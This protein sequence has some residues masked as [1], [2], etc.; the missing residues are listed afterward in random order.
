MVTMTHRLI[1]LSRSPTLRVMLLTFIGMLLGL[2]SDILL[3]AK[4]GTSQTTDALIVALS[5][6]RLVDLVCREGTR[7]SLVPLFMESREQMI[8][9]Q[10]HRFVSAILNIA[11]LA[12]IVVT[13]LLE[14]CAPWLVTFL[15]AGL[16]P[17]GKAEA[18]F[19]LR[20]AAPMVLFAPS[21]A[22]LSVVLNCQKRF[23]VVALRNA[24]APAVVVLAIA[25][26]W[27]QNHIAVW[28]ALAYSLGFALFF[29]MVFVDTIKAGH[30]HQWAA[31]P[32]Q[33]ELLPIWQ[34]GFLPTVGFVI[35]QGTN[36]IRT[37]FFPSLVTV[38][39]VASLYF[40][41]RI[42]SAAQTLLGVSLATTSLPTLTE[43]ELAG[44][45]SIL[46]KAL[47][48]N[49]LKALL[50]SVPPTILLLSFD[51]QIIGL[52]YGR[53][54]FGAESINQTSAVFFWLGLGL[55]VACL[56]PLLET[57]LYAQKA[58]KEVFRVMVFVSVAGV[59]ITWWLLQWKGLT[60]IAMGVV[61]M[62]ILNAGL[63]IYL[64][65]KRGVS[66]LTN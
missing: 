7:F 18:A 56:I 61:F 55:V 16:P 9:G 53:G 42:L 13:L 66:V 37:Q 62:L 43:H 24:A 25:L 39:G 64:L 29:V 26:G 5:L 12:G 6:P 19:L 20:A 2:V 65:K 8:Q 30:Q 15:A 51:K 40:A 22:V 38:G 36:L 28:V 21:I 33:E 47:Q 23:S 35:Q 27:Q 44:K 58:Y 52:L 46:T 34:A 50:V 59:G 57:G 32:S 11:I 49:L 10:Y 14:V 63:L 48:K 3:A 60:G 45:K 31:W 41:T 54:S 4:L 17:A 1:K